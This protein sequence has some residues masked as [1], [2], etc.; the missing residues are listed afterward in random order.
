MRSA[1]HGAVA[2]L[3]LLA[4]AA[5]ADPAGK[6]TTDETIQAVSGSGYVALQRASG[7]D[8]G[9]R[10][11]PSARAAENRDET[12]RSL[13]FFGQLTDPQ[14]ADEMSPA[15]V[16]FLDAA[17]GQIKSSWRPQEAVGLQVFD[18][19]VRNV[20]A[21]RTSEIRDGSGKKAKLGFVVTT[22][23]LADN[24]QLNETR[25]FKT[26]LEGGTVDPFSG[27]AISASNPCATDATTAAALNAAVAARQYTGV[28]DY[29]DYPGVPGE[30]YNGFW[31][32]DVAPGGGPYAVFPRYP[33]F[34]ER[35][36]QPFTA[37]GLDVP[38]YIARGN[39]D[40]LVQGNAPASVDLFRTI[41]TG[42]LKVFPSATLDPAA[43]SGADEDEAF[44]RIG[45]P[46]FIQTLLAGAK[47]VPPDPDRRILSTTEYKQEIGGSHGYRHV[48]A[49]E[50]KASDENATYYSFRPR[51]GVELI[52]LDTVAE[53]GGSTGN[54]DHPQ[55]QWLE[56]KLKAAQKA[57]RLVIAY[58]HHTL[59]T[60]SNS[61]KDEDAGSCAPTPK[62][63]CDADPRRSSP[64]HRGTAG[65]AS[66]K[67]L[68]LKYPNLVAYVAGHTH[69]NRIDLIRKG[70]GGFWQINTASHADTP[71]Q[72]RLIEVMDNRNGT[73]SLFTT[74]LDHAA[75][76][77]APAPGTAAA[78]FTETQLAS[79]SRVL[80]WN[81]PQAERG[82]RGRTL[83]RNMELVLRDPRLR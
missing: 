65:S 36:Q 39:H 33:G 21:N 75:P 17:G 4:P 23:D 19:V 55:Y 72:S 26:V 37:A 58:G 61:R 49:A 28:A 16:D 81:D 34:L 22:G 67:A 32:P 60:M 27:K 13:A 41:A 46:A 18:Q 40:G 25:W 38:W 14:I 79:V 9:I 43:F 68:L 56:R 82:A 8:H 44:R 6:S 80:A 20:N 78:G 50:R 24:Q 53:G 71:Q 74:V 42:C 12:R 3:L 11:H 10:R 69:D 47:T 5:A 2:A 70:R 73:L 31:D 29:D 30:R 54:L 76:I 66:V 64:I 35:A 59:A 15:R 48:E 7:E 51:K 52:S 57:K 83:D 63:G 77:A 62:P 45:D 1:V